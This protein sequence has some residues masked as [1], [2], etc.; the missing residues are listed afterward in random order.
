MG[1]VDLTIGGG[2]DLPSWSPASS[3]LVPR[4]WAPC[5][6]SRTMIWGHE[7]LFRLC[8]PKGEEPSFAFF[9]LVARDIWLP[10]LAPPYGTK[11]PLGGWRG[12]H[13]P[14]ALEGAGDGRGREEVVARTL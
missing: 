9:F 4:E 11:D 5:S 2:I 7:L 1:V 14:C 6:A 13:K 12:I 8:I 3:W 10:H